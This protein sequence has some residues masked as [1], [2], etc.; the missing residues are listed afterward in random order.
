MLRRGREYIT[1]LKKPRYYRQKRLYDSLDSGYI[2]NT[3]SPSPAS[4]LRPCNHFTYASLKGEVKYTPQGITRLSK[5]PGSTVAMPRITQ[6]NQNKP[7]VSHLLSPMK[8]NLY[9]PGFFFFQI[10]MRVSAIRIGRRTLTGSLCTAWKTVLFRQLPQFLWKKS[11]LHSLQIGIVNHHR[12][13]REEI[14]MYW[15]GQQE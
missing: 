15:G 2:H 3:R 11:V 5:Y 14:Y 13:T 4:F 12:T 10:G 9:Q 6:Q 1:W 8:I 7:L